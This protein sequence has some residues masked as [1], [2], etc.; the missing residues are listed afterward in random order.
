MPSKG[1]I[2]PLR[3]CWTR[4]VMHKVATLKRMMDRFG[5]YISAAWLCL[6]A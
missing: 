2:R 4:F 6:L 1:G 5:A 3:A